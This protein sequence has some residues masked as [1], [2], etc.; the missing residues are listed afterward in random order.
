MIKIVADNYVAKEDKKAFLALAQPLI[1][2]SRAEA[3]NIAYGLYEDIKDE[4]HLTFLEEWKDDNAI[5][6]HNSSKHFTQTFPK[7]LELC[8]KQGNVNVYKEV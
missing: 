3:G 5:A 7:L 6:S 4:T 2:A 1:E 8:K